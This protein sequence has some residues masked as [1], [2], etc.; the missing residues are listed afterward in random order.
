MESWLCSSEG[1]LGVFRTSSLGRE[2]NTAPDAVRNN[3][4]ESNIGKVLANTTQQLINGM[5]V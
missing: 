1:S 2:A 5:R 3:K 4:K